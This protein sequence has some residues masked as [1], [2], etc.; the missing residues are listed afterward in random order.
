MS[1]T[2]CPTRD[3]LYGYLVG[4]LPSDKGE[5]IGNHVESC[6]HCQAT[7]EELDD[8]ADILVAK[9]RGGAAEVPA[10][11]EPQLQ[12][13]LQR[14]EAM[15]PE[16]TLSIQ[17][18]DEPGT[19]DFG[20]PRE[21]GEFQL[22][23]KLGEGGMGTVYKA[24]QTKLQRIV[25]LKVLPP[26]RIADSQA[27]SRFEREMI[28]IGQLDHPNIVRPMHAGEHQGVS[29]LVMEYVEGLSLSQLV[30]CVGPL[31]IP[32]ACELIR[33]TAVGLQAAHEKGLVHR[34][35]KP[36]NLMLTRDGQVKI[37]DLGLARLRAEDSSETDMTG[38]GQAMGTADYIAPEQVT[39]SHSVDI[40]AD[41]YS[42]GCTLFKLLT[43]HAPFGR[44]R[45]DS[46][47]K[48]MMAHVQEP[49]PSVKEERDEVPV[50]LAAVVQ[51]MTARHAND[52]FAEPAQV[53]HAIGPFCAGSDL[54]LLMCRAEGV[55][56]SELLASR[57]LVGTDKPVISPA[58]STETKPVTP[59]AGAALTT[60]RSRWLWPVTI[61]L[62]AMLLIGVIAAWQIVI[63]ITDREVVVETPEGDTVRL[64]RG[65]GVNIKLAKRPPLSLVA[66]V[67]DPA[68]L[69]GVRSW[70]VETRGHRGEVLAVAYSPDGKW[71]ASGCQDGTIRIWDP[72]T[73][74]FVKALVGHDGVVQA[75]TWSRDNKQLAS[76]A[77]DDTIRVWD[78]QSGQQTH[79]IRTQV[80]DTAV[81]TI[82][83]RP[84]TPGRGAVGEGPTVF[85]AF[86]PDGKTLAYGNGD[87]QIHLWDVAT[88]KTVRVLR[89]PK[90]GVRAIAWSADS[91][92]LAVACGDR[93]VRIYGTS[94]DEV[95]DTFDGHADVV[96]AV[97]ISPDNK[98]VA[99]ASVSSKEQDSVR[100]WEIATGKPHQLLAAHDHGSQCVAFS[101][102]GKT[103][104]AGGG[105]GDGRL[106]A[107]NV[108]TG[109]LV[110]EQDFAQAGQRIAAVA[111]SPDGKLLAVARQDGT[112]QLCELSSGRALRALPKAK[113]K[114]VP[115]SPAGHLPSSPGAVEEFVYIVQTDAAQTSLTP[116]QFAKQYA[117]K[118]E[119]QKAT[120]SVAT[121][122]AKPASVAAQSAAK[123]AP[124]V[125]KVDAASARAKKP[126]TSPIPSAGEV[127]DGE[128]TITDLA[129]LPPILVEPGQPLSPTALVSRPA[130]IP[131]LRSWSIETR[132]FPLAINGLIGSPDGK[133]VAAY[134]NPKD[135]IIR[136]YDA[137]LQLQ[138]LLVGHTR[139]IGTAG[140][141]PDSRFFAGIGFDETLYIWELPS[142]RLLRRYL[143]LS[144][145]HAVE[146]SPNGKTVAYSGFGLGLL[147]P[148]GNAKR[149]LVDTDC[150]SLAW[151]PSGSALAGYIR[152]ETLRIWRVDQW[153]RLCDISDCRWLGGWSSDGRWLAYSTE[154]AVCLLDAVTY[155]VKRG[156]PLP[157][158]PVWSPSANKL[159]IER[160]G[161]V[162]V[163]DVTTGNKLGDPVAGGNA[164]W[165]GEK[166]FVSCRDN[167]IELR[168]SAAREVL[169]RS[170]DLGHGYWM[171]AA[172][173]PD[174]KLVVT[175][176]GDKAVLWDGETGQSQRPLDALSDAGGDQVTWSPTGEW[177][178]YM[179]PEILLVHHATGERRRLSGHAGGVTAHS[180]SPDGK[181]LATGGWDK[182]TRVW[183]WGSGE[184]KNELPHD[185]RIC[186]ISWS[187]DGKRLVVASQTS[188]RIWDT[189]TYQA[190]HVT[191]P[192]DLMGFCLGGWKSDGRKLLCVKYAGPYPL[193]ILDIGS[194][195]TSE[196]SLPATGMQV[197][198]VSPDGRKMCWVGK[199]AAIQRFPYLPDHETELLAG[200]SVFHLNGEKPQWL[201]DSRRLLFRDLH[202][203]ALFGYDT[204]THRR[205]GVLLP[206]MS[207]SGYMCIGPEGHYRG[208]P[209][210]EKH[211]V[212]VAMHDDGSQVTY[213]PDEFRRRFGWKNEPD[214]ARFLALDSRDPPPVSD[215]PLNAE[216]KFVSPPGAPRV[217]MPDDPAKAPKEPNVP[218]SPRALVS[219]PAPIAGLRSWSLELA[220]TEGG[221]LS[222]AEFNVDGNW[223]AV[224]DV[225]TAVPRIR[226]YDR[227][228][229]LQSV[230]LGHEAQVS[231]VSW[232]PDGRYLAST[233][234]DRT[235]R[236]WDVGAS[237][238]VRTVALESFGLAV[239]WSPDGQRVAV[240]CEGRSCILTLKTGTIDYF[241]TSLGWH[242]VSWS[243]DGQL[244]VLGSGEG[245]QVWD[246]K[247]LALV[248][249]RKPDEGGLTHVAWSPDGRWIAGADGAKYVTIWNAKDGSTNQKLSV[250]D[251]RPTSIAWSP[252]S[253]RLVS[254][255][256]YA[257][258]WDIATGK[259]L[260]QSTEGSRVAAWSPDGQTVAIAPGGRL[261]MLHAA[262]CNVLHQGSEFGQLAP[263]AR[264]AELASDGQSLFC[265]QAYDAYLVRNA[266]D[267][268]P[269]ESLLGIPEWGT[270]HCSP[271][272][273]R[274]VHLGWDPNNSNNLWLADVAS[275]E[276]SRWAVGH[277]KR[278]RTVAWSWDG[279]RLATGSDDQTALI[280]D[281]A[282]GQVQK[283][284]E[285]PCAVVAV[286]WSRDGKRLATGG[287]DQRIRI[288]DA[289][290]GKLQ[291]TFDPLPAPFTG[292]PFAELSWSVDDSQLA[293]ALGDGSVVLVTVQ[294][295]EIGPPVL[296][297]SGAAFDVRW[298]PDG[299]MLLASRWEGGEAVVF[300][301]RTGKTVNPAAQF[302]GQDLAKGFWL[303]DSRRLLLGCYGA[304]IQQG[305]DVLDDRPLGRL[306]S[307]IS[308]GQSVV[309]S[310]EGHYRGTRR[311]D[312][313]LVYVALTEDGR[314]ETYT[315]AAFAAKFGWKNDPSKA[316]LLGESSATTP[317]PSG[318]DR[319]ESS[320]GPSSEANAK[321]NTP[322]PKPKGE[323][324][325][326]TP[327]EDKK[328]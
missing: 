209:G 312:E 137:R 21:L 67:T 46:P 163:L 218:I 192:E 255:R 74:E 89:G 91:Q 214:K 200:M 291:R 212:Y 271:R 183:D 158:R 273:D 311:I 146:W 69:A 141:S 15:V 105:P 41:I 234:R 324:P 159:L 282:S 20:I 106:R 210:I 76:G 298:S 301:L 110:Y 4:A 17:R 171:R 300:S 198:A 73:G 51:R 319:S 94:S 131:G 316:Y 49:I 123:P 309:I 253:D 35:V 281:A 10:A 92:M 58:V 164:S 79:V 102:D 310:P 173:S 113:D 269:R 267:G 196:S 284:L 104:I 109:Q 194:H 114:R 211:I 199:I 248:F 287:A 224:A 37:L 130:P 30:R 111:V 147:S 185:N 54:P 33:Q 219:R 240:G 242:S 187:P 93:K 25:A 88:G 1:D 100:V 2:K 235:V 12:E 96:T 23:E 228:C 128:R 160:D 29:Y 274:I 290:D 122:G 307:R 195:Y 14:A 184:L 75:V 11:T 70:T 251:H 57:S 165:L 151:S 6:T 34:D 328:S 154:K 226:I 241:G 188:I 202:R 193:L 126:S 237:R 78:V 204:D 256:E 95:L 62:A 208:S 320:I 292:T 138:K 261:Q 63:R 176:S 18:P 19:E 13:A 5:T 297:L 39:D 149:P 152:P 47:F 222:S 161:L 28:A 66:L 180:W 136:I 144:Y 191:D 44:K 135:P 16:A 68:P 7:L 181:L 133:L 227:K 262:S 3:E 90:E 299:T 107:W 85:V 201:S 87:D 103:L 296:K 288:W 52:R 221:D 289:A 132:G 266:A 120:G 295:G 174:G 327:R 317:T 43:G 260:V 166:S 60:D 117:W 215:R 156:L 140:W 231:S 263:A 244:I 9:L 252:N 145:P 268:K 125:V 217:D 71:V 65:G 170:A 99:S 53:A 313:H 257:V 179:Q 116:Q 272:G 315:P 36:G 225:G 190:V 223:I 247:T 245:L 80:A 294:S 278:A 178:V 275:G 304:T 8:S 172:A 139:G 61:G 50:G 82:S 306:V 259:S 24:L 203:C 286:A 142:G 119:P 303:P 207:D 175:K 101:L 293:A 124:A 26:H 285:H 83:P 236:F 189:A 143:G 254:V 308:E 279:Q 155:V 238:L 239:R 283:K 264:S 169:T 177:I 314:Q 249:E 38:E 323:V 98:L 318:S 150:C 205:L 326:R 305:Y 186:D 64:G 81:T 243:P 167:L 22:L 265:L 157:G 72:T 162:T 197:G 302:A 229:H 32:E 246:A 250:P 220:G 216:V 276:V 280:W 258:V 55:D 206:S 40:R 97:A 118:N 42:L 77:A 84:G 325:Q 115:V 148:G 153:Q 270:R 168:D 233:G 121:S 134:G 48:I 230:L 127:A 31:P 108:E 277:A 322:R 213:T 59:A 182:V 56:V 45:Y 232:S 27:R 129:Q 86:S 321:T 112:V